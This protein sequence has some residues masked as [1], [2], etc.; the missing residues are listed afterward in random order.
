[1]SR[2][3]H[4]WSDD[5]FILLLVLHRLDE[6]L[7]SFLKLV[8]SNDEDFLDSIRNQEFHR[9]CQDVDISQWEQSLKFRSRSLTTDL[10]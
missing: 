3:D 8:L 10:S 4:E 5:H 2:V 9:V 6:L 7:E 1:M